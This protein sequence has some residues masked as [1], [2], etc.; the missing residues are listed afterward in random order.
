MGA[1][2]R[3]KFSPLGLFAAFNIFA[4]SACLRPDKPYEFSTCYPGAGDFYQFKVGD[5]QGKEIRFDSDEY[6]NR[7][8]FAVNVASF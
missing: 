8:I 7:I 1:R 2:Q 6:M 4:L 5:L 3:W